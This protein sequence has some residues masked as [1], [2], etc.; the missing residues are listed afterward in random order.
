MSHRN[1][2]NA[3]D[4][5]WKILLD[6]KV[7]RLPVDLNPVC[8]RLMIRVLTYGRNLELI[9]RANLS[10]AVRCTDGLTFF[11]RETP[12]I[13]F[14]ETK[15]PQRV[16]FTVAH[17]VGHIVLGHVS[18]GEITHINR[19]PQP[20]DTPEET[21]ANQF[22]AR[23]LAPACVL[24][25]LGIHTTE[26]IMGLCH[27]SRQAARFRANRMEELY[28]RGRFLTSQLEREVFKQFQPFMSEF[29]RSPREE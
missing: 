19:E 4:A 20:G 18:P 28:R 26:E 27:I 2:Q 22:A 1:Y 17:E 16:R 21:E 29:R 3:R 12:V 7:D 9:Q 15:L 5:A 14:D 8:R 25:G 24:W 10:E 6:C 13:L 11:L 23:L